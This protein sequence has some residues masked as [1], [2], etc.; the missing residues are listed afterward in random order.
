MLLVAGD[1]RVALATTHVPLAEVPALITRQRLTEVLGG[2]ARRPED[3]VRNRAA[4]GAGRG[5]QSARR[6]R[7]ASRARRDRRNRAGVPGVCGPRSVGPLPADTLFTQRQ[8]AGADAVLAMYHDQGLPV[9]KHVGFGNAV[10]VTLGLPIVRTSVD[11]GTALDLAGAAAPTSAASSP[12]SNSPTNSRAREPSA[13]DAA[14]ASTSSTAKPS[15]K[16]MA[17]RL[18]YS[19]D[20]PVLEIGPGEGA[21]TRHLVAASDDVTRRRNRPRSGC[22]AETALCRPCTSSKRTCCVSIWRR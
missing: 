21:L 5:P 20:D 6:R 19:R 18:A 11:H 16:Q 4:A 2:S 17:E 10:N 7:R 3:A 1:L 13:R 9:L 22:A 12:R 15:S 14:S 8:L